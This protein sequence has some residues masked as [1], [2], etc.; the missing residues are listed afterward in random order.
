MLQRVQSMIS[1]YQNLY[2]LTAARKMLIRWLL[3][4]FHVRIAFEVCFHNSEDKWNILSMVATRER[5][6]VEKYK[7]C[8]HGKVYVFPLLIY[9]VRRGVFTRSKNVKA[10]FVKGLS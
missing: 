8:H 3:H 10:L 5:L 7:C 4:D 2:A 1:S 6:L 9:A